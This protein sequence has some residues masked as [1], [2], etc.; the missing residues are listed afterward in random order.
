MI[1][2]KTTQRVE[3]L[4]DRICY[5]EAMIIPDEAIGKRGQVK[6]SRCESNQ[7]GANG[8]GISKFHGFIITE[9]R[10]QNQSKKRE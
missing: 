4:D 9:M 2:E 5:N 6:H 1:N 10:R 7:Q 3:A 8:G